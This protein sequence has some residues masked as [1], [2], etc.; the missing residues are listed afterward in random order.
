MNKQ[1]MGCVTAIKFISC[2][3]YLF[4]IIKSLSK[5]RF[6]TGLEIQFSNNSLPTQTQTLLLVFSTADAAVSLLN[7]LR[8]IS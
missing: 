5:L 4:L 2:V 8:N 1:L 7:Q 6:Q 3:L